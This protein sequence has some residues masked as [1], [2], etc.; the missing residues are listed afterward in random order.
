MLTIIVNETPLHIPRG[1]SLQLE[2]NSSI[3]STEKIQGDIVFT[4]DIP[5]EENDEVFRHA[6]FTYVQR[7]RKLPCTVSAV[8]WRLPGATSTSRRR[9]TNSIPAALW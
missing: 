7:V 9:P 4:F 3:F 2:A 8:V 6:R 5:A 1:T